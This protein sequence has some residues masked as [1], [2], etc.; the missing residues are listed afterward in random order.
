M[1][2][3]VDTSAIYALLD[4]NDRYHLLARSAWIEWIEQPVSFI[5]SNYVLLESLA[6]I[7][8]RLGMEAA[9]RFVAEM[10]PVFVTLDK[11]GHPYGRSQCLARCS[12]PECQSG[13]LHQF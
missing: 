10:V 7:Q 13:G 6:L 3:F 1:V 8:R 4:A 2:I 12:P 5:C 9:Q 11:T